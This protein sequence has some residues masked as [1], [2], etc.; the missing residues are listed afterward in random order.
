MT[1]NHIFLKESSSTSKILV[2]I[3]NEHIAVDINDIIKCE[4]DGNYSLFTASNKSTYLVSKSLKYYEGL[5]SK[6][7]F[8]R[9]NRSTLINI[10]QIHSIYKKE[11]ITLS[12]KERIVVSIRNKP[13]LIEL[14]KSLS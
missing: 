12:N 13:K 11:A 7:G 10:N 6:K 2:H 9:A 1:Q 8:F 4:A 5:L 14:I 3:G